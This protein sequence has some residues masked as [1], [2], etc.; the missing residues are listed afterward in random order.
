M[1]AILFGSIGTIA[2]TSELQREAF[3][4]AFATHGLDWNWSQDEYARLL[5]HSGGADRVAAYAQSRGQEVDAA[6][7]H[8]T[9]SER[10]Q[11]RLA[12]S[13]LQPRAGVVETM[14]EGREAGFQLALVTTT[15]AQ[16]VAALLQSV[17]PAVESS[18]FDLLVDSTDV[19]RP[20]PDDA[21]Y[22]FAWS[23]STS[24]RMTAWRS[25]TTSEASRR[26]RP[27]A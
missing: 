9:K 20:K 17:A 25:R 12:E 23:A 4:S 5:G 7:I 11:R 22:R 3:N 18:A 15:S 1:P 26:R 14:R 10:F 19:E 27:R 24:S 2:D 6:A 21:A 16:N 13:P 8:R